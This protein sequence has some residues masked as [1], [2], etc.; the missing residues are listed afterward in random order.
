MRKNLLIMF[1]GL[2]LA[3]G[4]LNAQVL[5]SDDFESYTIGQGI[6]LQEGDVWDT[7]SGTPGSAEDPL[8]S[9]AYA[10]SG[11]QSIQVAGTN[12]GVIEFDDLTTGRYRIEFYIMVPEGKLGYYN[13]MQ[14]F[15][16]A[17]TGLVWGM[18]TMLKDGEM[19][20]DGMG[21]GAVTYNYTPGT[22]FK[23]QHFIDLNSDWF[24]MYIDDVLV[25]AYQ[26][27]KGVSGTGSLKKLDAFDFYAWDDDGNGTPE[28]YMDNFLIEEVETP[29]PPTNFAYTLENLNDV[30]LTW[31]APTEGTPESYSIARNG[32]VIGTTDQLT[33][34]DVN[35]YPNTYEYSLLAFYGTSSGYS[36]PVPLEVIIPGG[37][38]RNYVVYEMFTS[39]LCGYCPYVTQAFDQFVAEAVNDMAIIEYHGNGLGEDPFTT[40]VTDAR[41]IYYG[42]LYELEG[43]YPTTII[44]GAS[45]FEGTY[46]SVADMKTLFQYYYDEQIAIPSVYTIETDV[47]QLSTDPYVF[48]LDVDVVETFPYFEDATIMFISLSETSIA[49]SWQGQNHLDFVCRGVYP[50]E[51]G[52]QMD[53]SSVNTYINSFNISI[54]PTYN[55]D[56]CEI[57]VFLQNMETGQIQ[58]VAKEKL[59]S[60]SEIETDIE[61]NTVV[62]P[63]PANE[64]IYVVADENINNIEV[65]NVAGQIVASE[66]VS[67]DKFQLNVSDFST[68]VYFVK[69]YTN[70]EISVHK[71]IVE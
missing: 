42:D 28:Y 7:W 5:Y 51:Y 41:T 70:N 17:G 52:I 53:F 26:W 27:S 40:V 19:T 43:A 59:F 69:V 68:G 54:D 11:V 4:Y 64:I 60:V 6:A 56:N 46:E 66:L 71:I 21:Y 36:A 58:Q 18:Q 34:T 16:P 32:V 15:N 25:H 8:V 9:D 35:V 47:Q 44:N 48:N 20:I 2:L 39:I 24:D 65:L 33:F 14:N 29:Y 57:V 3:A 37:N 67:A 30:V 55:V 49:Y 31:D 23:V 45:A 12:D 61:F 10:H 62:F 50:D 38:P 1:A 13:I 22:W 63:N